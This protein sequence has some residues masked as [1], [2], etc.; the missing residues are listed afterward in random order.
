MSME[1]ARIM[2]T[3]ETAATILFV[4]VAGEE[5]GL[6]G[7]TFLAQSLRSAGAD[8][9]AA[10]TNDIVGSST[11]DDGSKDPFSIRL[12]AQGIPSN[13][14]AAQVQERAAIGGENDSPAR[15][16]GRFVSEV[17]S[18]SA[19][20]MTGESHRCVPCFCSHLMG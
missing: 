8:V 10:F 1:L 19:T 20:N 14:T 18:N 4:A 11:A 9:Q 7:S 15:Q 13:E 16:I 5:Q 3:H 6:Y 2:A 17:A 12:F